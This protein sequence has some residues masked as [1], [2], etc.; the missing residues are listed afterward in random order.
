MAAAASDAPAATEEA[1]GAGS[2]SKPDEEVPEAYA[3]LEGTDFVAYVTKLPVLLGR[4]SD[5]TKGTSELVKLDD[6]KV[7]AKMP[8]GPLCATRRRP[9]AAACEVAPRF[10]CDTLRAW[11][12]APAY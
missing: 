1:A 6:A 7:R 5:A 10:V 9:Q 3:K 2:P 11:F 8:L 12:R 4:G